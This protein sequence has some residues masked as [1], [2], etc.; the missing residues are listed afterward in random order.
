[1]TEPVLVGSVKNPAWKDSDG[2]SHTAAEVYEFLDVEKAFIL[3]LHSMCQVFDFSQLAGT[4][5]QF[6]DSDEQ[7]AGS[8]EQTESTTGH[9]YNDFRVLEVWTGEKQDNLA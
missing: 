5:I 2:G 4:E 7:E 9:G 3:G 8:F 1:M 6:I